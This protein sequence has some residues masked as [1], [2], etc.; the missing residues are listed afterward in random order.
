MAL[1]FLGDALFF[2]TK[3]DALPF[4]YDAILYFFIFFR[5][6]L[7]IISGPPNILVLRYIFVR[8]AASGSTAACSSL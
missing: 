5:D 4:L 8:A 7:L 6:A 2:G 1:P 3:M